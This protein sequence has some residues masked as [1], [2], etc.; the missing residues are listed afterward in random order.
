M[1][2]IHVHQIKNVKINVVVLLVEN[3]VEILIVVVV[4]LYV[5]DMYVSLNKLMVTIHVHLTMN[6][7][8]DIVVALLVENVVKIRIVVV[9]IVSV[10]HVGSA[11]LMVIVHLEFV[12]ITSV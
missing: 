4:N 12:R 6:A 2:T 8:L 10:M 1:V 3:V 9:V 7:L 5:L 11:H